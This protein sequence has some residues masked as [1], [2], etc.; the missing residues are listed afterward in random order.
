MTAFDEATA[1]TQDGDGRYHVKPDE[2]FAIFLPDGV[3]GAVNGGVLMATVLRAVSCVIPI[4]PP[5]RQL[6]RTRIRF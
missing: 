5:G 6:V 1:I 2:R 4:A 3:S